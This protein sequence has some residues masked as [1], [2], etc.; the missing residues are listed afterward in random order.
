VT[1]RDGRRAPSSGQAG[2]HASA[3]ATLTI[4]P[5]PSPA[6]AEHRARFL[7]HLEAHEDGLAK[8]CFPEHLTAGAIVVSPDGDQVLLNHHRKADAW[9]AFGGHLEPEDHSLAAG[10]RRELREESGLIDFE[11]DHDPLC[12]DAHAVE[13]CSE[14]GTVQHLDVRFLAV[15]DPQ[16]SHAASDESIDVRWWPVDALPATFDDMYALIDAAVARTRARS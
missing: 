6:Q 10:A 5:A 14:R 9:L 4:W 12:L 3:V 13:F 8:S 15:A 16:G 7:A 11:L 1:L 2:L